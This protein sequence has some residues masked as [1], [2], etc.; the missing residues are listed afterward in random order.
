LKDSW[1][2]IIS[3]VSIAVYMKIDQVMLAQILDT[4]A[5]GVYS[6]A[7]GISEIWYF[8]PMAIVSSVFPSFIQARIGD[9]SLYYQ[10]IQKLFSL[11]T[12]LSLSIALPM[13]FLSSSLIKIFFGD[14]YSA[15][16]PVLAIHIWTSLFVFLGVAQSPWDLTENLTRL[17]L[18]RMASGAILNII[19]NIFMIP[20]YGVVGAALATV[21]SQAFASVILNAVHEKTKRIFNLQIK[22]M[23]FL[24]DIRN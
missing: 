22:A 12:V 24:Q 23:F 14:S 13:T 4:T 19:L 11:M 7:V 21:I 18:F 15:A 5:V 16:G 9:E 1:P 17:A 3:G 6:A 8:I 10:R 2:M 20:A